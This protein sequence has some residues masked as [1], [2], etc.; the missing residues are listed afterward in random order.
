MS[1]NK[2]THVTQV[3][4]YKHRY[5]YEKTKMGIELQAPKRIV[6]NYDQVDVTHMHQSGPTVLIQVPSHAYPET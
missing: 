6:R 3:K 5:M 1:T 2:R 4:V